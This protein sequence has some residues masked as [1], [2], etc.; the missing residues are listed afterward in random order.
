MRNLHRWT[1]TIVALFLLYVAGSGIIIQLIDMTSIYRHAPASDPN[2]LSIREGIMG[3]PGFAVIAPED[4]SAAKLPASSDLPKLLA[5]VQ[6]AARRAA[7]S[8]M[9]SWVELRM[10]KDTPVG[11]VAVAGANARRLTFNALTGESMGT[12]SIESPFGSFGGGERSAHDIVKGFHRGDVVGQ[13]GPVISLLVALAMITMVI[14]GLTLY[15]K[16][17]R[18]RQKAGRSNWFW[19]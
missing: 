17:L 18:G 7:P 8:E 12:A 5:T 19:S 9:F 4:Y 11:V 2:M 3:P 14:S 16:L 6:T 1:M 13:F 15:F 10:N